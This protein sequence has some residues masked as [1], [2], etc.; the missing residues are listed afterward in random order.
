LHYFCILFQSFKKNQTVTMITLFEAKDAKFR[1]DEANSIFEFTWIGTVSLKS[2]V[3]LL[4]LASD[5]AA[6]MSVV[7]WLID[8]SR[9]VAYTPEARIWIK[10]QFVNVIGIGM[11]QK[12]DKMAAID[13]PDP[14]AQVSSAVLAKAIREMNSEI[15]GKEFDYPTVALNWLKGIEPKQGKPKKKGFFRR[16]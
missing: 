15:K 8:R 1:Y 12:I 16:K 11:I 3:E 2:V 5:Q 7:H 13:S 9:L 6:D 10:N 4:T 14:M